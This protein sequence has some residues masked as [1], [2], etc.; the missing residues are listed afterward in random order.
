MPINS[1]E[2]GGWVGGRVGVMLFR[3]AAPTKKR[4]FKSSGIYSGAAHRTSP[5]LKSDSSEL[6]LKR[7]LNIYWL[8]SSPRQLQLMCESFASVLLLH[9]PANHCVCR[10]GSQLLFFCCFFP[11]VCSY[12]FISTGVKGIVFT[13]LLKTRRGGTCFAKGS[14]IAKKHQGWVE[15]KEC[16]CGSVCV[17]VHW[18]SDRAKHNSGLWLAYPQQLHH[19]IRIRISLMQKIWRTIRGFFFFLVVVVSRV[20]IKIQ[21]KYIKK[22]TNTQRENKLYLQYI[23]MCVQLRASEEC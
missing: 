23:H 14:Q 16:K 5:C 10:A 8:T 20:K 4:Y 19:V 21:K 15:V 13:G 1:W 3:S 2:G 22:S 7:A 6:S 11:T 17:C 9:T 18:K 12:V